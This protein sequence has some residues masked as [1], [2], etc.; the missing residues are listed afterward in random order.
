MARHIKKEEFC[1]DSHAPSLVLEH[2]LRGALIVC[3]CC[4]ISHRDV[5]SNH[6]EQKKR[7]ESELVND[8]GKSV[9]M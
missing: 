7:I 1:K 3:G 8:R 4:R 2:W 9:T 6:A 5:I